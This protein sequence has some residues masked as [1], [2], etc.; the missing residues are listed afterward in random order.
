M[1]LARQ[2]LGLCVV[3][4]LL[5]GSAAALYAGAR[6]QS[7]KVDRPQITNIAV[8]RIRV[9]NRKTSHDFYSKILGLPQAKQGCFSKTTANVECFNVNSSQKIEL[10]TNDP[11]DGK[12]GIEAVA[13]HARDANLMREYLVARGVQVGDVN[14]DAAGDNYIEVRDPEQHRVIFISPGTGVISNIA[15]SPKSNQLIHT[16]WVIKDRGAAD[17]FYRDVLGFHLYWQGGMKDNE[18]SWVAMQEPNG[19]TWLEYM[20]NI[21]PTAD[22]HTLGVMN[23]ISLGVVSIKEAEARLIKN[24]W[25]PTEQPKVGRDGKWQLNVYDPDDTRVEF[26]EFK[27]A[28]RPCCSEF[29]GTH[30]GPQ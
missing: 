2:F 19:N 20:L 28:E 26:M 15:I 14:K 3:A 12:N 4:A 16:G 27:P 17:V 18:T 25:K 24:G 13:Y 8:V 11:G 9:T 7:T 5:A 6:P 23:H 1:R 21:S 22:H 10:V 30:P 29:T